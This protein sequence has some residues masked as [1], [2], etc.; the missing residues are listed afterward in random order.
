MSLI[1]KI[2]AREANLGVIG[3]GYVGL[4][5]VIAF[6]R[7]GFPV[8]GFDIDPVKVGMLRQ[9][10]SYIKHIDLSSIM[11]D[12]A[13]DQ[14]PKISFAA[15]SDFSLLANMDCIIICV[16]T[17]LDKHREPDMSFVFNT[18]RSIAGYLRKGQLIAL[19]S[20]TYPGTTDEDI[21]AILEETGLKAGIDFHLAFSPEREDPNNKNYST[22]NIPKV[23]GGYT[24]QC[25]N[26]AVALYNTI[27]VRTIPVS[28]TKV[29]EAAKLLENIYRSVNIALVNELKI[30]FD[31]MGIDIWEVIEAASTKPFG[32]QAFYPGPGLGGHC[33]PIDPFYLT[34]KVR[35][36]DFTTRFIELAGEI[37]TSMPYYVVDKS[38]AYLNSKGKSMQGSHILILGMAYKK[39]ID[40]QR[41]SASL[42]I[43]RLLREKGAAIEYS[44]MH[45]PHCRGHRHY[46][47][48]DMSSVELTED[49][50]KSADVVLLLT[51]HSAFDYEFIEK[52]A[53]CIIDTR[54]AF[55]K[56]GIQSKKI[57][58]A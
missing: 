41:E 27:V 16:P 15:T 19:E 46:P 5:I 38:T 18:T 13:S 42:K 54:N 55:A 21:K 7:A 58:K 48:I 24:A 53:Q 49:R 25:L 22:G 4:P 35:E 31:K 17:P 14:K 28:S 44:D 20:T 6:C 45:V 52:H 32:F 39:D 2:I 36:F 3:L 50:L 10:K 40:D 12:N 30:I 51:D 8:T 34:W 56:R 57:R 29:A 43:A 26:V 23:V 37:N 11:P 9:G 33:I 47:D 1:E